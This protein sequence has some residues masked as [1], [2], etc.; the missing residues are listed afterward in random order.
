M[1]THSPRAHSAGVYIQSVACEYSRCSTA[2][3]AKP[4]RAHG[5]AM[6]CRAH[7]P[8]VPATHTAGAPA[9][10]LPPT[11]DAVNDTS[12]PPYTTGLS[13]HSTRGQYVE[14]PTVS[15][16]KYPMR[17]LR[18]PHVSTPSATAARWRQVASVP[19]LLSPFRAHAHAGMRVL[20]RC[21]HVPALRCAAD[22]SAADSWT[23]SHAAIMAP[24]H[25]SVSSEVEPSTDPDERTAQP[26][27]PP[28]AAAAGGA[29]LVAIRAAAEPCRRRRR[30]AGNSFPHTARTHSAA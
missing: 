12:T 7:I 5:R 25:L 26:G 11:V 27:R 14:C 19:F 13:T 9:P 21:S 16:Q 3:A 20:G 8:L 15:T 23:P 30:L 29:A 4:P 6:P 24:P 18:A 1:S 17:V 28:P 10:P 22:D 2:C